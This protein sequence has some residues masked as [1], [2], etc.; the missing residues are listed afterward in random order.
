[1]PGRTESLR[2]FIALELSE[3]VRRRAARMQARLQAECMGWRWVRAE[4]MHLTL[5][6][7]GS[8]ERDR[9]EAVFAAVDAAAAA[10]EPFSFEVGGLGT[11][12]PRSNPRVLWVGVQEKSGRLSLLYES[13][14][15]RLEK[16]GFERE[17]R[18]FRPHITLARAKSGGSRR[19]PDTVPLGREGEELGRVEARRVVVMR[20]ILEPGGAVYSMLHQSP[21]KGVGGHG[22]VG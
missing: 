2:A 20:S 8:V 6:F 21:M 22:D 16:L 13:L 5:F 11:F 14:A 9:L 18:P 7:L 17:D 3:E 19:H 15:E 4:N 10:V 12:G 1:M